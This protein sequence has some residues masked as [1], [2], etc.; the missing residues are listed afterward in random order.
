LGK[1]G[2]N[3]DIEFRIKARNRWG[4]GPTWSEI[5]KLPVVKKPEIINTPKMYIGT[6]RGKLKVVFTDPET[7]GIALKQINMRIRNGK[8]EWQRSNDCNVNKLKK[9]KYYDTKTKKIKEKN[10]RYCE[11]KMQKLEDDFQLKFDEMVHLQ[12]AGETFAGKGPWSE[13]NKDGSKMRGRP[14][15]MEKPTYKHIASDEDTHVI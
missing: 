9:R 14:L 11:I 4:D 15:R 7:H 3:G 10:L 5:S 6:E 12:V 2:K 1:K 8:G 13:E